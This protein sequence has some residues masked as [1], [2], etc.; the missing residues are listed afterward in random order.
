MEVEKRENVQALLVAGQP[1]TGTR[2][3]FLLAR[4]QRLGRPNGHVGVTK[5]WFG[6][7]PPTIKEDMLTG[8]AE[9]REENS[10]RPTRIAFKEAT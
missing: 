10:G 3:A 4:G 9:S 5:Q 7:R 6:S 2:M 8:C 1:W